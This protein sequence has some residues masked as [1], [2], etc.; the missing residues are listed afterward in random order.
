MQM[1]YDPTVVQRIPLWEFAGRWLG[2]EQVR[3]AFKPAQ[4]WLH[5][6]ADRPLAF[7][8]PSLNQRYG[9][10]ERSMVT[11][12]NAL[13]QQGMAV[14]L[15][16]IRPAAHF[17]ADLDPAVRVVDL[18]GTR[19]GL[20]ALPRVWFYLRTAQPR[21]CIGTLPPD[22][23]T[24]LWAAWLA[25][26]AGAQRIR[27]VM[28][29]QNTVAY[30]T[31]L[32]RPLTRQILPLLMRWCYPFADA[33]VAVSAGLRDEIRRSLGQPLPRVR[34]IYNPTVRPELPTLAAA[35]LAEVWLNDKPLP[36]L[37][38][39]GRLTAQKDFPNLL[40]AVALVRQQQPVRLI[41]LGEGDERPTLEALIVQ[42]G[43]QAVVKLAGYTS[44][45]YAYMARAD[46]FV[47]SSE[48]EGLPG[49]LLEAM[50]CGTPVVATDCEAGPREI[51]ADG[52]YG[53]LVPVG[54]SAALAQ[55]IMTTL[56]APLPV[57][58]LQSR[59]QDFSVAAAVTGYR[60]LFRDLLG[61]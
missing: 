41:I 42:L 44:N 20:L 54:D 26:L 9:G 15:V 34:V 28:Q 14:D 36:V 8:I 46:L 6:V 47:L 38:G 23:L 2:G 58:V 31:H 57:A 12:A 61:S 30:G 49:V 39:V 33:I 53:P 40:R 60:L 16:L 11:L 10:A 51:L 25:R 29:Y 32:A 5:P 1:Q 37:L 45:P 35:P 18:G 43:L 50:A 56:A 59:A 52:Q 3:R 21:I 27:V 17:R 24:V 22:N 55:A 7:Y 4:A 48:S 13:A 19:R